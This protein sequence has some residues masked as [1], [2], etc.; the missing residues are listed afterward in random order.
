MLGVGVTK[1]WPTSLTKINIQTTVSPSAVC[2][3]IEKRVAVHRVPFGEKSQI[4]LPATIHLRPKGEG[5]GGMLVDGKLLAH[6]MNA[7]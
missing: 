5:K 2:P 4:I 6:F 1:R 7:G 3:Q